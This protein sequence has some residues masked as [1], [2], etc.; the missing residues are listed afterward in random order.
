MFLGFGRVPICLVKHLYSEMPLQSLRISSYAFGLN[1][2][3]DLN[4]TCLVTWRLDRDLK[5]VFDGTQ[6][7][8]HGATAV[9]CGVLAHL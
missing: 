2:T 1:K 8:D 4:N 3:L 6:S 5:G 9:I 7:I